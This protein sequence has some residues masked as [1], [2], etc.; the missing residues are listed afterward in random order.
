MAFLHI[1]AKRFNPGFSL[2]VL[3]VFID[4]MQVGEVQINE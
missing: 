1:P 2:P 4:H 3:S